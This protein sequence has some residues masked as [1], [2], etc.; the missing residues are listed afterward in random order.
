MACFGS[1][2]CATM[3]AHIRCAIAH[4]NHR[5]AP[6]AACGLP[7][8]GRLP[9]LNSLLLGLSCLALWSRAALSIT[10]STLGER[11]RESDALGREVDVAMRHRHVWLYAM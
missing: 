6:R 2:V 4:A 5:G 3:S 7:Q 1:D 11:E 10:A 8:L 9:T